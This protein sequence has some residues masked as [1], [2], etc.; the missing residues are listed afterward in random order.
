MIQ[1]KFYFMIAA[2]HL[3]LFKRIV[4]SYQIIDWNAYYLYENNYKVT[5]ANDKCIDCKFKMLVLMDNMEW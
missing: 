2:F 3:A 4:I 5:I 1:K